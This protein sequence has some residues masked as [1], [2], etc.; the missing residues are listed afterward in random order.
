MKTGTFRLHEKNL[1]TFSVSRAQPFLL[2][3]LEHIKSSDVRHTLAIKF[4]KEK[5]K[6]SGRSTTVRR[7]TSLTVR[8]RSG[9]ASLQL[10][11]HGIIDR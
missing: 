7:N 6:Y 10:K 2:E 1:E 9:F 8:D 4:S 3:C 11:Y 5:H